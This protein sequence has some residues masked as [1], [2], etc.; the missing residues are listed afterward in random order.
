M[1]EVLKF[2]LIASLIITILIFLAFY[3]IS[4]DKSSNESVGE[5]I[6][7]EDDKPVLERNKTIRDVLI[8]TCPN[9]SAGDKIEMGGLSAAYEDYLFKSCSEENICDLNREFADDIS[10]AFIDNMVTCNEEIIPNTRYEWNPKAKK[11]YK[12]KNVREALMEKCPKQS[13][14][15]DKINKDNQATY[16]DYLFSACKSKETCDNKL[17][18]ADP[19]SKAIMNANT[20]CGSWNING[21]KWNWRN[22]KW[23]SV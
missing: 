4:D 19:I 11:W 9:L 15:G 10:Q 13:D 3:S 6:Y 20:R 21:Y 22:N 17:L 5:S 8:E 12:P 23:N 14:A 16:E 1:K 7:I 18:S 2:S